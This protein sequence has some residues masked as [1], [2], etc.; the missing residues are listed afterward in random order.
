MSAEARDRVVAAGPQMMAQALAQFDPAMRQQ[1]EQRLGFSSTAL[2]SGYGGEEL[3]K[4][5]DAQ[6][7]R[8]AGAPAAA[9]GARP[10]LILDKAWHGVHYVLSGAAGPGES[11]ISQAVLGGV[12]FHGEA[13]FSGYGSA[14]YFT[15]EQV[16]AIAQ[17]LGGFDVEHEAAGRFDAARMNEL[18]IYPGW[19]PADAGLVAGELRRLRGFYSEA[20]RGGRAIVTSLV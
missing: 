16:A 17:V 18:G 3:L 10:S 12:E 7:A 14:R 9:Q 19:H 8:L 20:G 4:L 5:M 6:Q 15:V 11:L 1:L 2:A 13:D